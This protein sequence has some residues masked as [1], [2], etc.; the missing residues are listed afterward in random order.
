MEVAAAVRARTSPSFI[1]GI[2]LNSVEFQDSGFQ[3]EEAREVVRLLEEY[4][5]D[6]VELSGGTYEELGFVHKSESSRK[7]ESYFMEF[8][9]LI[10][11]GQ[12][13]TDRQIK[14][15]VTGGFRTVG[16]MVDALSTIDGIGLGRPLCGEPR[17]VKDIL[18][19]RVSGVIKPALSDDPSEMTL[20][21]V[22]GGVQIKQISKDHEP[23]DAS[24]AQAI[25]GFKKD[26][27]AFMEKVAADEKGEIAT[28]L[29]I[30][31]PAVPYGNAAEGVVASA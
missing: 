6:F 20:S 5:F 4:K 13:K 29:D 22:L 7:R 23:L 12:S 11:G 1:L 31:A 27:G 10:V 16:A 3:P 21:V 19:G 14:V 28:F 18:S 8:A 15:Y 9:D 2:K 30:S 26:M 24:D 17:I 25:E